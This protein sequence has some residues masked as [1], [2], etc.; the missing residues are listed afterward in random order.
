MSVLISLLWMA[1]HQRVYGIL[2]RVIAAGQQLEAQG[3]ARLRRVL[4][5]HAPEKTEE[6]EENMISPI[7]ETEMMR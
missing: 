6:T 7:A 2:G 3:R 1:F 5:L 4:R